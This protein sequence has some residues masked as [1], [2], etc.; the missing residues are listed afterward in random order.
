M[1][2]IRSDQFEDRPRLPRFAPST[3]SK[4]GIIRVKEYEYPLSGRKDM[5]GQSWLQI[6]IW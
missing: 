5:T 1:V 3:S 2:N 4:V 6:I